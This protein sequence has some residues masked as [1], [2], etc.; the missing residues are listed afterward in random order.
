MYRWKPNNNNLLL[1]ANSNGFLF[2][3]NIS[4]FSLVSKLQEENNQI[5]ALDY[6]NKGDNFATAG[7]DAKIRIYDDETKK[8]LVSLGAKQWVSPGHTN[9]IFSLKF[10]NDDPNVLI[11]G[12]WD[13][14]VYIWDIRLKKCVDCIFGV[15]LMGDSLDYKNGQILIGNQ[16][17]KEQIQLYDYKSRNLLKVINWEMGCKMDGINVYTAQFSKKNGDYIVAGSSGGFNQMKIFSKKENYNPVFCANFLPKGCY[18]S[19]FG[20]VFHNLAFGGGEGCVYVCSL[21][22]I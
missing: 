15:C 1:A 11:S 18:T 16:K 17:N 13:P 8:Q 2:Q 21:Q 14:S 5:L 20:N 7:K 9:R 10:I 22:N 19:D 3:Y 6:N 4:D 12:G